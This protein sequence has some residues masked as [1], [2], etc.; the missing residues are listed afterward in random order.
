MP[1]GYDF[2]ATLIG[3]FLSHHFDGGRLFFFI[4]E[5]Q[6]INRLGLEPFVHRDRLTH[7]PPVQH[8]ILRPTKVVIQ[9]GDDRFHCLIAHGLA[10]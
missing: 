1:S 10:F 5:I 6:R 3:Q 2:N 7:E 4:H 8:P 9:N